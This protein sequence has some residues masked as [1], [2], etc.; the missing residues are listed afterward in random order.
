MTKNAVRFAVRCPFVAGI[1]FTGLLI[2]T[3]STSST[4]TITTAAPS[5]TQPNDIPV[6]LTLSADSP[7]CF[8]LMETAGGDQ[9]RMV[10]IVHQQHGRLPNGPLTVKSRQFVRQLFPGFQPT[11]TFNKTIRVTNYAADAISIQEP[12][13]LAVESCTVGQAMDIASYT[14][15]DGTKCRLLLRVDR[16]F[17]NHFVAKL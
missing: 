7:V 15:P 5:T 2:L 13:S 9:T 3:A 8:T 12:Q 14:R 4:I 11:I 16:E 6:T 10:A 17:P 1:A